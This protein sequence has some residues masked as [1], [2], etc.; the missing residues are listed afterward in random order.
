MRDFI[1]LLGFIVAVALVA[2]TGAAFK[3][4]AW[5]AALDKPGWTPPNWLFPVAWSV[6]YLLIAV[7]GWLVWREVG[8]SG[9]SKAFTVYGL[10]LALNAAWSW[11]FFGR[12]DMGLAFLD[13]VGLWLAIALTMGLFWATKPLAGALLVPYLLWVTYAAALNLTIWRINLGA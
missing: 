12:H 10:Q 9:A 2:A 1:V 3:P 5:Y 13:I 11:L 4:G 8:F 7:A 6:L